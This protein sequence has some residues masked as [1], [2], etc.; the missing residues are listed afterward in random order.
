MRPRAAL[1][2]SALILAVIGVVAALTPASG[3]DRGD[4]PA[5]AKPGATPA[6]VEAPIDRYDLAGGCYALQAPNGRWVARAGDGFAATARTPAKAEP[7]SFKATDLGSYLLYGTQRDFLAGAT[8]RLDAVAG[9]GSS[10]VAATDPSPRADFIVQKP[11]T[12]F[13]LAL[14]DQILTADGAGTLTLG[15]GSRLRIRK[16]GG[17][18]AFPELTTNVTGQPLKGAA[19]YAEVKGY[20]DAHLHTVA[21]EFI[22][23]RV[24]CGRPFHR[25]GVEA[26][27]V[28]CP[29]HEPGGR[30]ALL[31][32]ILLGGD[33]VAGHDTVG[34]PTFKDWPAPLSLTHEQVYYKWL[35]RSWRS[36]LRMMTTLLVDNAVL[37][38]TYPYQQNS[39]NEMDG[40]RLQAQRLRELERYIDAQSGGPGEGWFRIVT[41]PTQ[42]RQVINSGKLAV[43]MGIEVSVLFD[44]G[45]KAGIPQCDEAQIDTQL[46]E[47]YDLGVRQMELANK[48]DNALTG[49]TGDGGVGGPVINSGNVQETGQFWQFETCPTEDDHSKH[50]HGTDRQQPNVVDDGGAPKEVAGRDTVF[51]EVL[52]Q[53]GR[54]GAAP[55]YPEGPHCNVRGL[56]DLGKHLLRRMMEK[57]MLFDP[58]H[59]S[60]K[61][62]HEALDLLDA[63]GYDGIVSSHSWSDDTVYERVVETGGVVA[64]YAGDSEFFVEQWKRTKQWAPL[65]DQF[66]GFAW[67]ADANGLGTQGRPRG[68][69]AKNPVTYPF[70]GL[71]GV[72]VD[73]QVS[74]ERVYDVNVDG[75]A[76][77][78]LYADW[79]EDLR[80][81]AGDDI[82]RDL[83]RGPEAFLQTWERSLG[84]PKRRCHDRAELSGR[85]GLGAL[86]VGMTPEQALRT[87]GQPHVREAGA[88]RWCLSGGGE[89]TASFDRSGKLKRVTT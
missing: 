74:G 65:T 58:D 78:G 66:W 3:A 32:A 71:G 77:Y 50:D 23:G 51:G 5:P 2:R 13:T 38:R 63:A 59:M 11:N 85:T 10:T 35:E 34:Y 47:V 55:V 45:L 61:A 88:F 64:S 31:D 60:A 57:G 84:V 70:S 12:G 16:T 69:D 48:F 67:G 6:R 86:R 30:G 29:D 17:C 53:A 39:C 37:C 81:L 42:A 43:T 26:A 80:Q 82:V 89:A 87:A 83:E 40:V 27:L 33:P 25:Y 44:C 56:T 4:R 49:V 1:T 15:V 54:T 79:V 75:V 72:R 76:H 7:F 14:G 46:Q 36:G 21:Y 24:H 22:G 20:L 52:A 18:T 73:K 62:R 41:D 28:D 9:P 68:K 19:P 8:G